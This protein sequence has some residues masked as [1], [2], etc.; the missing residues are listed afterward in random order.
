MRWPCPA[1]G[2]LYSGASE[3]LPPG[4][5]ASRLLV[6]IALIGILSVLYWVSTEA[7]G[8][9]DLRPYVVV[10]FLPVLTI[11]VILVLRR[12]A[13]DLTP[14]MWVM[15]GAYVLAKILEHF[16]ADVLEITGVVSGHTPKHVAAALAPVALISALLGRRG[17][18]FDD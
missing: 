17:E 1:H 16:D 18:Q 3:L 14:A 8:Q 12:H 15:I 2:T 5:P 9:G 13:S 7:L 6:P 11:P 4:V 10:Q